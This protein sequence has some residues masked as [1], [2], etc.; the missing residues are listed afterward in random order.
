MEILIGVLL[1][2]AGFALR[3]VLAIPRGRRR[4]T[5]FQEEVLRIMV[6]ITQAAA[7]AVAELQALTTA[8]NNLVTAAQALLTAYQANPTSGATQAAA[9]ALEAALAPAQAA[10]AAADSESGAINTALTPPPAP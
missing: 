4:L 7:D 6:N 9:D 2:L 8:G 3:S 5:F 10:V 1:F